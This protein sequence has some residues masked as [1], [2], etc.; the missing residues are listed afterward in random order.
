MTLFEKALINDK[1][2]FINDEYNIN[3]QDETG[4]TLLHYAVIGSAYDVIEILINKGADV[5]ILDNKGESPIFD[6]AIK[7]KLAIA[8]TLIIN[9][10]K[11]NKPNKKGETL[12]HLAASKGDKTFIKL[13]VENN[14]LLANTTNEGLYPVHYAILAGHIDI[15]KYLL[16]IANQ[17]FNLVDN[18]KNTLLHYGAQTT[19]DLLIYYLISE[20]LNPN[21]LNDNFETPLFN[22]ARFGTTDTVQ[23]LLISDAYI[24]ILN[25]RSENPIDISL[26]YGKY[27]IKNVLY[28]YQMLP[29]YERLIKRQ[30]LTIKVLNRDY[31]SLKKALDQMNT[32]R[33]DKYNYSALDY[34]RL[35]N[36]KE[37]I[38][39]LKQ[40]PIM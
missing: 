27:D 28:N 31:K 20:G 1:D 39:L 33:L 9:Y 29:K 38:D 7:A 26:I 36:F 14:S 2:S 12:M 3:I 16:G 35:Y 34:A 37:A 19:N 18:K 24:D 8:K 30:K 6:C 22:A 25:I 5:N 23:A 40:I 32:M 17:S 4:K 15:I 10:A 21:F 13:L 11:L